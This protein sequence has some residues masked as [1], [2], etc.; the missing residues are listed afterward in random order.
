MLEEEEAIVLAEQ[1]S[2]IQKLADSCLPKIVRILLP[3]L[4]DTYFGHDDAQTR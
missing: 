4:R 1:H 3:V 2:K